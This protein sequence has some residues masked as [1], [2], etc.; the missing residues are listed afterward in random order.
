MGVDAA[1]LNTSNTSA[2][3]FFITIL[4]ILLVGT[5]LRFRRRLR[6]ITNK[7][8]Y[9]LFLSKYL[10]GDYMT[11][12]SKRKLTLVKKKTLVLDL[13]E[14]LM[15]SV[16]VK[17][18]VKGGRGSKKKCKWHYV[19]VD[20]EFNL[21]DSTVKVYKRPFVDHFL[22]QVSKWFDIVVFTAGTEPY[23]TPIIDYLDGGRNILGHRL[24]RDKC[25]TVQGF[26]AKFVSIVNDD[27]ANVI[28]LDNSIPE[29]CF[30]VDNSIP[31]FDYIIGDWDTEL[32]NLLPFLDAIRFA[33]DV[34]SV[35][36]RCKRLNTLDL[37]LQ[38]PH[39]NIKYKN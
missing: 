37:Y 12:C 16:F 33:G 29:C 21:H 8:C 27:K 30:N 24:F 34:R 36:K 10:H 35:L 39:R 20:F 2:I 11:S 6:Y 1:S 31:I 19:P 26:N 32:L 4:G 28:L 22:D 14:T 9:E 15:T 13:D 3:T 38:K 5:L 18:G 17:K 7:L 25:V 23:A